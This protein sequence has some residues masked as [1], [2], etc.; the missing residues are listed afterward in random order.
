M[1]KVI[2]MGV[3]LGSWN[4]VGRVYGEIDVILI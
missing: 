2:P 3:G 4:R 1:S